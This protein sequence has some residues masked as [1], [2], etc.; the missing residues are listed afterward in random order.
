[1][2]PTTDY[3]ILINTIDAN[4]KEQKCYPYRGGPND[5]QW[6]SFRLKQAAD[7]VTEKDAFNTIVALRKYWIRDLKD[8][9]KLDIESIKILKRTSTYEEIEV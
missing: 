3:L 1:M 5:G 7:Y 2:E 9:C 4:G 6:I 8:N